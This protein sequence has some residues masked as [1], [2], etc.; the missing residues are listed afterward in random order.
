MENVR[1]CRELECLRVQHE[2]LQKEGFDGTARKREQRALSR[3]ALIMRHARDPILIAQPDGRIM[4][5]NQAAVALYG[6]SEAEMLGLRIHD[7][8]A[9]NESDAVD[10]QLAHA[11]SKGLLFETIHFRRDGTALPVEVNAQKVT[12]EGEHFILSIVRDMTERKQAE[13]RFF[14]TNQRF[15]ALMDALPVGVSFSEDSTCRSVTGNPAAL[16]QFGVA[17]NDNLSASALDEAAPGRQ[18]HFFRD[19]RQVTDSELPLQRAVAENRGIPP[20]EL[21]VHLPDGRRWVTEASGAPIRDAS[22][23]VVAGVAVTVDITQRK[24]EEEERR[25]TIEFLN[26]VNRTSTI[27]ALIRAATLFFQK[28]SGCDAVGVRLRDGEDFPYYETRGFSREFVECERSLCN[29]NANGEIERDEHGKVRLACLCGK[30]LGSGSDGVPMGCFW[31]ND[32]QA[33]VDELPE[34]ERQLLRGRCLR[35]GYRS[36]ALFALEQS[37]NPIGLL[38]L[39]SRQSN[40]FT[41]DQIALWQRLAAK[42]SIAL[43]KF[44]AEEALKKSHERLELTVQVRTQ[45]L[46]RINAALSESETRFRQMA[47]NVH[48]VFYLS[49]PELAQMY[50]VSPSFER[51]WGRPCGELY[52]NPRTWLNAIHPEH[53][54]DVQKRLANTCDSRETTQ[55]EY[56]I[57]RPDGTVRWVSDQW[58]MVRD[59]TGRVYRVAG[60]ARDIT[61]RKQAQDTL[62]EREETLRIL[63]DNLPGG[64]IYQ[65]VRAADGREWYNYISEGIEDIRGI[66]AAN[67]L[68]V[69]E[70]LKATIHP[71]DIARIR[72]AEDESARTLTLCDIEGRVCTP[73]G[74]TKWLQ[75]HSAPRRLKDGG[76]LWDGV[77]VDITERKAG[78]A[79]LHRAN[80]ALLVL[81]ECD[82]VTARASDERELLNRICTILVEIGGAKMAWVGFAEEDEN[83]SVRPVA[84][85]GNDH[86]Y[87]KSAKVTWADNLRGQGPTGMAIR[88]CE[89]NV[90]HDIANDPR[91]AP[92]RRAQ[93]KR[94]YA[95]SIALP[96]VW[97]NACL[98]ALTIYSPEADAFNGEEV[99]LLKQLAGDLT[100]GIYALR[101]RAERSRLQQELLTISEREKQL[102]SQELHDGLCQNLAG[103]A[104]MASMLQ[105]RLEARA[106]PDAEYARQI[107]GMLSTNVNETRN[108]SHGLHPVGPEGEGLMNALAQLAQSVSNL[109]HIYCFFRCPEPVLLESEIA[110]THLFRIT[111]EAINNARKHGEADRIL[112]SLQYNPG[113]IRLVIRDNGIGI[114]LKMPKISGL[115]IRSMNYR[116]AE[117]GASLTVRRAGKRGTTV[118]CILPLSCPA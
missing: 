89:V 21:E 71:D 64:A 109:F 57:V 55:L 107:C 61:E 29:R 28:F 88:T 84:R 80:R 99:E 3:Y 12:L 83:K 112:I 72:E 5:C 54:D 25:I 49:H 70:L 4:E 48:D 82:E 93:L 20:I 40:Q 91:L 43:G 106:D 19:G 118:T 37:G 42:F 32:A 41:P 56:R 59:R 9:R 13:A 115:G 18:V 114:P 51:V 15:Q 11:S 24:R 17:E 62:R 1:L 45:E 104:M 39:N 31:T 63:A 77:V 90:C 47:E 6:Y 23:K 46:L 74:K 111:Q 68:L 26:L 94:G 35:E 38:Q 100:Y 105:R 65:F 7:L 16:A 73:E 113:E 2:A 92:W 108:L 78:E 67:A 85:A 34:A 33:T 14:E 103:T 30:M 69:P 101:T 102:I 53:R 36:V 66:S 44:R 97:Q 81:R 117:I 10:R 79:A 75:W 8:R 60:V 95:A 58:A 86:G 76:T 96:L 22:G 27:R 98:G 116:A 110:S 50:Y 52:A 87:L